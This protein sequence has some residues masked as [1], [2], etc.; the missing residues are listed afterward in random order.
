[1]GGTIVEQEIIVVV[2]VVFLGE[3]RMRT[4]HQ[5]EQKANIL[6][7]HYSAQAEGRGPSLKMQFV[8]F[9]SVDFRSYSC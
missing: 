1:M 5:N 3:G 6:M 8:F 4:L 7:C 2:V 9:F